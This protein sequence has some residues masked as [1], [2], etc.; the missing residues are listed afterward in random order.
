MIEKSFGTEP[1][2]GIHLRN[3]VDWRRA[4][5]LLKEPRHGLKNLMASTQCLGENPEAPLT[6]EMCLPTKETVIE[7]VT[8]VLKRTNL[9]HVYIATDNDPYIDDFRKSLPDMNFVH[10]NPKLAQLDLYILGRSHTFIGNCPSSFSSVV[11]RERDVTAKP[12]LYFGL[13]EPSYEHG[14]L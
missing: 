6:M 5:D 7:T 12:T 10:L 2:L 9:N 8:N 1:F 4:C 13:E 11:R 14:E 3:G